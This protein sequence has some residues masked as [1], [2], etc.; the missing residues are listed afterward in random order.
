MNDIQMESNGFFL[1]FSG[2]AEGSAAFRIAA[3][4]WK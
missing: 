2:E 3:K 1:Y 4:S